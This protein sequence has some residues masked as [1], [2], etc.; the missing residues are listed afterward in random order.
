M[1]G[2]LP[3]ELA[4]SITVRF[5]PQLAA[6]AFARGTVSSLPPSSTTITLRGFIDCRAT[7]AR[8]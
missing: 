5:M 6:K 3:I 1:V 4:R 8:Q 2:V 7:E